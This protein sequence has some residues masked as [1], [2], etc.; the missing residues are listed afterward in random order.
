MDENLNCWEFKKC[1]YGPR[2]RKA[3]KTGMC[4]AVME[5]RLDGVHGG[6]RAGRACW[7]VP[8]TENCS[9]EIQDNFAV[10]INQCLQCDFYQ[11]V[12]E[13][14]GPDFE[15]LLPLITRLKDS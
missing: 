7:V 14:N 6:T 15:E 2:G 12:R 1:G 13:E 3:H 11:K 8:E 4:P 9:N 10:K 5:S